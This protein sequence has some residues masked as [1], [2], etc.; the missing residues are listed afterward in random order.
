MRALQTKS[1][2]I[3]ENCIHYETG[4]TVSSRRKHRTPQ[5][6]VTPG[7][8][9]A[10]ILKDGMDNLADARAVID[11]LENLHKTSLPYDLNHLY[12]PRLPL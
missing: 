9:K 5:G 2:E 1:T 12:N 7:Q 3:L 6:P 10:T 4:A 11:L 8:F